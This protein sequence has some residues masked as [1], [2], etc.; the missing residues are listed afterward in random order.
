MLNSNNVMLC[1]QRQFQET[2]KVRLCL[3][4]TN[5]YSALEVPRRCAI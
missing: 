5:A 3:Q 4:R 1:R 2:V